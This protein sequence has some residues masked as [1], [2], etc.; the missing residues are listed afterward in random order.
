MFIDSLS[1]EMPTLLHD[2]KEVPDSHLE[3]EHEVPNVKV[4]LQQMF[5]DLTEIDQPYQNSN[6][7]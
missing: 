4:I 3:L 1:E 5:A 2:R 6:Q 7:Q